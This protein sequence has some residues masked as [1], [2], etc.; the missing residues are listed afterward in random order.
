MFPFK[1]RQSLL[2][3]EKRDRRRLVVIV[4]AQAFL[5][6]LDLIGIALIGA[7]GALTINGVQSKSSTGLLAEFTNFVGIA[8]LTYQGQV[9]ILGLVSS[10]VLIG[11]TLLSIYFTRRI[12]RFLSNKG[13]LISTKLVKSLFSQPITYVQK[14][15]SQETL[16]ALTQGVMN[17]TL[18]VLGSLATLFTDFA[19]LLVLCLGLFIVDP[20]VALSTIALFSGIGLLLYRVLHQRA[21]ELGILQTELHISSNQKIFELVKGYR[22]ILVKDRVNFYGNEIS[23]LRFSLSE[24]LADSSFLPYIGKYVIETSV[25]IG[26]LTIG[27]VQFAISDAVSAVSTL[28]IFLAAGM[29][30]APAVLRMQQGAISLKSYIGTADRTLELAEQLQFTSDETAAVRNLSEDSPKFEYPDFKSNIKFQDVNFSYPNSNRIAIADLSFEVKE[31]EFIAIVGDSGAGK[32]TIADLMLGIISPDSGEIK[33]SGVSPDAAIKSWPG[34]I[35]YV[36]QDPLVIEGSLRENITLGYGQNSISVERVERALKVSKLETLIE[37]LDNGLDT[38]VGES[39]WG[40]SGGQK[41]RL[42]IARAMYSNPK[43][44]VLDEATSALDAT[45]ESDISASINT[46]KGSVT[47]VMIAHR[48]S[49]VR[50]ANKIVYME[51]GRMIGVGSFEELRLRIDKFDKQARLMGL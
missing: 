27:A 10:V 20:L 32:S 11:K 40:I 3:L 42:G 18:G 37:S 14:Q 45:T 44:L 22:E 1:I 46:L 51:N 26:G 12:L 29:R 6:F 31:G 30:I 5:S 23:K 9:V 41:Q 7:I 4:L 36:P 43:L 49:I 17:I 24:T 15:S 47:I 21:L 16:F 34:A 39:G 35:A 28:S 2:L 19:L 25:L 48:L 33:V 13:A 8:N 50:D 38:L